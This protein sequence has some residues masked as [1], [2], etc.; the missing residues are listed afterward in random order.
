MVEHD[1]IA[2]TGEPADRPGLA[3]GSHPPGGGGR[4]P[5]CG[6]PPAR[7]PA[8]RGLGHRPVPQGRVDPSDRLAQAPAGP[9]AVPLWAVQRLDPPAPPRSSKPPAGR[10]PISEAYFAQLLGLPFVA[11]MPTRDQPRE[12][13][14]IEC[15]GARATWWTTRRRIYDAARTIAAEHRRALHGPVPLRGAGD[16]LARQQQ[17]RRDD[18]RADA[19]G[20]V[21][22]AGLD[23]RR[24]GHRRHLARRSGATSATGGMPPGC[25]SSTRRGSAFFDGWTPGDHCR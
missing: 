21:S 25:A 20:A 10:P 24:G 4:E 16:R 19:A 23:R 22:R 8:A 13:R 9:L 1:G 14:A 12:G 7:V 11:V 2:R 17:H 6:H 3:R 5:Q 15:S 18:L